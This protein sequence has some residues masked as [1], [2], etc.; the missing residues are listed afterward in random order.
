MDFAHILQSQTTGI[1]LLDTALCIQYMNESAE[2]MINASVNRVIGLPMSNLLPD[3]DQLLGTCNKVLANPGEIR[4]R[5]HQLSLSSSSNN[6]Q[7]D[8]TINRVD[9]DSNEMLLLELNTTEAM[10]KFARDNEF[11]K[12]QQSNQAVIRGLAHEI[13]NPLG[14]IRGAAQLLADEIESEELHDYTRVI[15]QEADRLT[16][17][18]NRMQAQTMVDLDQSVNIH[19]VIEHV[20]QLMLADS[21]PAYTVIQDYDPSLPAVRGNAELLVQALIN[22]IGNAV[23]AIAS[24]GIAGKILLRTRID[25][26]S[27]DGHKMQVVRV[28]II[29]NGEGVDGQLAS[30]IFDPMVTSKSGGTGLGLPITAEIIAQHGGA[31]DFHCNPGETTFRL[32]LPVFSKTGDHLPTNSVELH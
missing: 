2:V 19:S 4:L 15:I 16:N 25:H 31:I 10:S 14:G 23:E 27:L 28:D 30:R 22:V 12:R 9:L 29:D 5:N 24:T 32:F 18:V 26:H 6:L 17:L 1:I 11:V 21:D 8:C 3:N 13:R 20:R 7:V